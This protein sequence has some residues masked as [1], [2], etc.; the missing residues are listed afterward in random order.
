MSMPFVPYE[1]PFNKTYK[2]FKERMFE[3]DIFCTLFVRYKGLLSGH[4]FT[5]MP[6]HLPP[7]LFDEIDYNAYPNFLAE[8]ETATSLANIHQ[9]LFERQVRAWLEHHPT[10][11]LIGIDTLGVGLPQDDQ[12]WVELLVAGTYEESLYLFV[13]TH[14]FEQHG[15][16]TIEKINY[17]INLTPFGLWAFSLLPPSLQTRLHQPIV[18]LT[19][20]DLR[21]LV[22]HTHCLALTGAFDETVTLYWQE[23]PLKSYSPPDSPSI[24]SFCPHNKQGFLS[25]HAEGGESGFGQLLRITSFSDPHAKLLHSFKGPDGMYPKG[26]LW[27]S[28]EGHL[29]GVTSWGGEFEEGVVYQWNPATS[30][31]LFVSGGGQNLPKRFY[32]GLVEGEDGHLYGTS[33]LGGEANYGTIYRVSKDLTQLE[34]VHSFTGTDGKYLQSRLAVGTAGWLY[35]ISQHGGP[36]GLGTVFS[37]NVFTRGF[38]VLYAFQAPDNNQITPSS[39]H[40]ADIGERGYMRYRPGIPASFVMWHPLGNLYLIG[41]SKQPELWCLYSQMN[42]QRDIIATFLQ[43]PKGLHACGEVGCLCWTDGKK[44]YRFDPVRRVQE[45]LIQEY[46]LDPKK[47]ITSFVFDAQEGIYGWNKDTLYAISPNGEVR[48]LYSL[49]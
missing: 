8:G 5:F 46:T 2:Y 34:T 44:F 6:S 13:V 38:K 29:Y 19:L 32:S 11:C 47:Q 18:S 3:E 4:F 26:H 42:W 48:V 20:S 30:K 31:L 17:H 14:K 36:E 12:D 40:E 45:P 37:Y 22:E 35:G 10:A 49:R 15:F 25:T 21:Y 7:S 24:V 43:P 9:L 1:L 27:V 28:K 39:T 33:L 23:I 16:Q 41:N